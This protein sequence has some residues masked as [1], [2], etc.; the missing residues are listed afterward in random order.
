[1]RRS[2]KEIT[3]RS[4][5]DKVIRDCKVCHLAMTAD[6]EPYVVPISFGYDG[7]AVYF[8]TAREGRKID[9]FTAN[10]RVCVQFE[11]DVRLVTS[12]T[13][14]CDWTFSFESVIG[15]GVIEELTDPDTKA[16]GLN[17]IMQQ[18]SGRTWQF[19]IPAFSRT[20][21]WRVSIDKL[22]GKLSSTKAT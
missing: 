1:M 2:D 21:V 11:H 10:P 13:D 18:Y 6:N 3:S 17:Q 19:D 8:H 20:R 7:A 12:D 9:F 15:F 4:E 16:H 14:A 5:I 22:S